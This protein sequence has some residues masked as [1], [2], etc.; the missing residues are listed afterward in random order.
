MVG[1]TIDTGWK[2][3]MAGKRLRNMAQAGVI[4]YIVVASFSF[5]LLQI[6]VEE[7]LDQLCLVIEAEN[8]CREGT[9]AE[10]LSYTA[11]RRN[12]FHP[13]HWDPVQTQ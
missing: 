1:P 12:K 4:F 3:D 13:H 6:Q 10:H 11:H 9:N 8:N 5:L 7:I 2:G